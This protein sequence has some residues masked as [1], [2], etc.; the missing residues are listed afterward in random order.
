MAWGFGTT[1]VRWPKQA[2]MLRRRDHRV[3]LL[4]IIEQVRTSGAGAAWSALCGKDHIDGLG[5]AFGTKFLYFSGYQCARSPRP[6]ILDSNVLRALNHQATG[7][8]RTFNYRREDYEAYLCLA[9]AWAADPSWDGTPDVVE[10]VLFKR[11]KE[12]AILGATSAV[13]ACR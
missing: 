13:R 6:L 2:A 4:A 1:S 11:G 9:E 8:G 10:Y 12:L 5:A 3:K 7:L